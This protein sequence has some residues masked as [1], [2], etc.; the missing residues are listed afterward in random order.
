MCGCHLILTSHQVL[1]C[2]VL[3]IN[4]KTWSCILKA[5]TLPGWLHWPKAIDYSP[6]GLECHSN[7]YGYPF[8][9]PGST[10]IAPLLNLVSYFPL[11]FVLQQKQTV[12]FA[13][14]PQSRYQLVSLLV[15]MK[16]QS[17]CKMKSQSISLV[18]QLVPLH[19]YYLIFLY[20]MV[21]TGYHG[22]LLMSGHCE[23]PPS[24]SNRIVFLYF[25]SFPYFY[26]IP[27]AKGVREN[28]H[29]EF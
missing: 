27:F 8:L 29:F 9:H 17:L 25:F 6:W 10:L 24:Q 26:R 15:R 21:S 12:S 23:G 18:R 3:F 19:I 20:A 22:S 2:L 16:K 1:T 11:S 5:P 13:R 4:S 28:M 7:T 14:A